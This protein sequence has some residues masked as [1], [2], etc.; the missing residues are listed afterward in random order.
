MLLQMTEYCVRAM[1]FNN[2]FINSLV[3]SCWS[4]LLVEKTGENHRTVASHW[5]TLSHNVV[6]ST[7][8][9]VILSRLPM[10]IIGYNHIC[11]GCFQVEHGY[12]IVFLKRTLH[13]LL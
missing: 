10:L 9:V 8:R 7:P 12:L 1:M 6:S 13:L 3:I 5:Q 11:I 4:V 2:T